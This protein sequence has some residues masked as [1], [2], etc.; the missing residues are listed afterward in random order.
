[1]WSIPVKE[2]WEASKRK[3]WKISKFIKNVSATNTNNETAVNNNINEFLRVKT[4]LENTKTK[5]F[6]FTPKRLKTK[7]YLL[8]GLG[9]NIPT[10]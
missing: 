9:A 1:M 7:Y 10:D 5:F 3:Q 8:K 6:T 4:D 2:I